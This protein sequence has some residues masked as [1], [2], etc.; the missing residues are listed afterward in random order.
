MTD[1][2]LEEKNSQT[3]VK[4]EAQSESRVRPISGI[5]PT[6]KKKPFRGAASSLMGFVLGFLLGG[7]E[8]PLQTYPLGCALVASLPRNTIAAML[9]MTVRSVLLFMEGTDLLLP[10]ICSTSLLLC[11]VILNLILFH[12]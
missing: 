12:Q 5:K 6:A 3:A 8:F 11:R 1:E 2:K 4:K 10:M 7:T 9:G